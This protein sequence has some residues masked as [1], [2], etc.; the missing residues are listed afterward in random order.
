MGNK[1][2]NCKL[3]ERK[4]RRK[5]KNKKRGNSIVCQEKNEK[6]TSLNIYTTRLKQICSLKNRYYIKE[7]VENIDI[8]MFV[9]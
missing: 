3:K 5:T 6:K 7:N 2:A 1:N 4:K 9:K 8:R